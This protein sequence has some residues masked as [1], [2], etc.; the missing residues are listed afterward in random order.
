MSVVGALGG[1]GRVAHLHL[2][3]AGRLASAVRQEEMDNVGAVYEAV[4]EER[5]GERW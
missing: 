5:E 1:M 2:A 3:R 4:L